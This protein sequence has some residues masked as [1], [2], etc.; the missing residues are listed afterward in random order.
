VAPIKWSFG[1]SPQLN[2][3]KQAFNEAKRGKDLGPS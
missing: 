1:I 2:K 3:S